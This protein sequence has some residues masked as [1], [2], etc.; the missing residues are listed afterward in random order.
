MMVKEQQIC[1]IQLFLMIFFQF[2]GMKSISCIQ[3][4]YNLSARLN[5][6]INS[7][8]DLKFPEP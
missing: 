2:K 1:A 6:V 3:E 7:Y 4:K 5:S 8:Y